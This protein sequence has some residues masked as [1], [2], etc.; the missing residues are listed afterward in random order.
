MAR[1]GLRF[2]AL[3]W[4]VVK[5]RQELLSFAGNEDSPCRGEEDRW[6]DSLI[7]ACDMNPLRALQFFEC[8]AYTLR[9]SKRG[10]GGLQ[11]LNGRL[12]ID[13]NHGFDGNDGSHDP[14]AEDEIRPNDANGRD[15]IDAVDRNQSIDGVDRF[16]RNHT[17]DGIFRNDHCHQDPIHRNDGINPDGDDPNDGRNQIQVT[18]R[19]GRINR[20]DRDHE[21]DYGIHTNHGTGMDGIGRI[22]RNAETTRGGIRPHDEI[23]RNEDDMRSTLLDQEQPP[24][25]RPAIHTPLLHHDE[26]RRSSFHGLN[27]D[28]NDRSTGQKLRKLKE[29]FLHKLPG[30]FTTYQHSRSR[31]LVAQVIIVLASVSSFSIL[32]KF[33]FLFIGYFVVSLLSIAHWAAFKLS[34][35]DATCVL[36]LLFF[37]PLGPIL[38]IAWMVVSCVAV[39]GEEKWFVLRPGHLEWYDDYNVPNPTAGPSGVLLLDGTTRIKTSWFRKTQFVCWTPYRELTLRA[40]SRKER[41]DWIHQIECIIRA[42]RGNRLI[43]GEIA[44]SFAPP[45]HGTEI[46]FLIDG[47]DTFKEI[48]H[49]INNARNEIFIAGWMI[50]PELLLLRDTATAGFALPESPAGLFQTQIPTKVESYA[51]FTHVTAGPAAVVYFYDILVIT[52][53]VN[54][55]TTASWILRGKSVVSGMWV[56]LNV[57]KKIDLKNRNRCE[58]VRF[59]IPRA[60]QQVCD[61]YEIVFGDCNGYFFPVDVMSDANEDGWVRLDR[62][63]SLFS[64]TCGGVV[65]FSK[66]Q[67]DY[68]ENDENLVDESRLDRLLARKAE[69][70]VKIYVSV[71]RDVEMFLSNNSFH[72]KRMLFRE[73][74]QV[75]RHAPPGRISGSI[76]HLMSCSRSKGMTWW[77]HHEKIVCVDQ[78]IAFLG[79]LDLAF[80]RFDDARHLLSDPALRIW[81]GRDYYNARFGDFKNLDTNPFGDSLNRATQARLPWHDVQIAV[82]GAAALDV[83]KH[84]IGRWN[85]EVRELKKPSPGT[86]GGRWLSSG[87]DYHVLVP[88][89]SGEPNEFVTSSAATTCQILRSVSLWSGPSD[90]ESSIQDGMLFMI[91]NAKKYI[92]IEQQFFSSSLAGRPV[93]NSVA[94]VLAERLIRALSTNDFEFRCVVVLPILPAF[95]GDVMDNFSAR[96]VLHWNLTTIRELI[97]MV[98][99]ETGIVEEVNL[100]ISFFSLRTAQP[101]LDGTFATES[102]YVH[103]KLLLVDDE[104][105]LV[106]SANMNDRSLL[107]TRD[108]EIAALVYDPLKARKLRMKLLNEHLGFNEFENAMDLNDFARMFDECRLRAMWNTQLLCGAFPRQ[109]PREEWTSFQ[110][111]QYQDDRVDQNAMDLVRNG[112][113]KGH[114]VSFPTSF[115]KDQLLLPGPCSREFALPYENYL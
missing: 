14:S 42:Q 93:R 26:S 106:G 84:F 47:R 4:V 17:I 33:E 67:D 59:W 35:I 62:S 53:P 44:S 12:T 52:P 82:F 28:W 113:L 24:S 21:I 111:M 102:I 37:A 76:Q 3:F 63:N 49:A 7:R 6:T 2:D 38:I 92:Y 66:Q 80:G 50:S 41:D 99:K 51:K 74:I 71:Y 79:G 98:K 19:F 88:I 114:L 5:S 11:G 39:R 78:S 91:S 86:G 46:E 58:H 64:F 13:S 32:Q 109:V 112:K 100:P 9:E 104:R 54:S 34:A 20:Y 83:S 48:Y 87:I 90:T 105:V 107:G 22:D 40:A 43:H 36:P 110:R 29:S 115:L 56:D 55:T 77:S 65:L 15:P 85:A 8:S 89:Y 103:S 1:I 96:S 23:S 30:G 25:D 97:D 73:N 27:N 108:S 95:E 68:S 94:R 61:E 101:L 18:G 31:V 72:A 45:R 10:W 57:Q 70:G 60:L 75:L 81:R 16:D 69:Q